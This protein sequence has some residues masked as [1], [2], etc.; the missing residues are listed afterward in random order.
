VTRE[1]LSVA[2][3]RVYVSPLDRPP[4]E[5]KENAMTVIIANRKHSYGIDVALLVNACPTCGIVYGIP[6]DFSDACYRNGTRYYCPNGHSLGWSE[7]EADRQRKRAEQLA[8]RLSGSEDTAARWREN[9]ERERRS[10]I[11]YK[12]HMTRARNRIAAG[13]CPVPGCKRSGFT[14]VMSHIASQHPGWVADHPEVQ[15]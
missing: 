11:A 6:Q 9:A 5:V 13:V 7:T 2:S 1:P 14:Q 10:A 3:V 4:P 15:A 8:R 12:G